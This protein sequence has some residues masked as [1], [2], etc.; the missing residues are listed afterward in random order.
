MSNVSNEELVTNEQY[1]K[2]IT[3]KSFGMDLNTLKAPMFIYNNYKPIRD[4]NGNVIDKIEERDYKWTDSQNI[5]RRLYMYCKGRLPRQFE[6]DVLFALVGLFIKKNAPFPFNKNLKI[7]EINVNAVEFS[8]YELAMYLKIEPTGYYIQRMKDAV[9]ILKQTQYFS[10]DNGVL[11]DKKKGKYIQSGESG[12]SLISS[13]TFKTTSQVIKSDEYSNTIDNN[14]VEFAELILNNLRYEYFKYLN[15]NLYFD[16]IPSGITRGIYGYIEANRYA[17]NKSQKYIKRMYETLK[18][19]IPI[20]FNYISELKRRIDKPL[21]HLKKIGYL[22][23]YAYGDLFLIN[24]KKENCIYFCFDITLEELKKMLER[25]RIQ[26]LQLNLD[27]KSK[28]ENNN[29]IVSKAEYL[30]LPQK[31]LQEELEIRGLEIKTAYKFV[32]TYDKWTIIKYIIWFD[33]QRIENNIK[34]NDGGLIRVAIEGQY[35]IDKKYP[36]IIQFIE[37]EK[38]QEKESSIKTHDDIES[39]Y[40]IYIKDNINTFKHERKVEYDILYNTILDDLLLN[41]DNRIKQIKQVNGDISKLQEF[42]DLKE[43][44]QYFTDILTKEIKV[45]LKLKDIEEFKNGLNN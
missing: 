29:S 3:P 23:D 32:K 17:N 28:E 31:D 10:Y 25:K 37:R 38:L 14:I 11:Y 30:K 13:Y 43:Q 7:Y 12:M 33:K 21:Q 40:K 22:K 18:Y 45:F 2:C 4:D 35:G 26:Q 8:W 27:I 6:S 16:K 42:I 34:I 15:M 36:E 9:K 41:I 20:E 44:S 39:K 19:G 5:D 24:G 1:E